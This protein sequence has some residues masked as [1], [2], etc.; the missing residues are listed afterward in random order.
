MELTHIKGHLGHKGTQ[1]YMHVHTTH[2]YMY[3]WWN[4]R[5]SHGYYTIVKEDVSIE[6]G[7]VKG[8]QDLPVH[9]FATSWKSII[10]S[11]LQD[12]FLSEN[13]EKWT[14]LYIAGNKT[15]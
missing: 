6:V 2:E 4:L 5:I 12:F 10:I 8:K 14:F 9:L 3:N 13:L 11:K 15:I 7:G 1:N